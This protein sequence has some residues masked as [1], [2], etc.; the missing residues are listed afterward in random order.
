M[1]AHT[2]GQSAAAPARSLG[3]QPHSFCHPI[4]DPSRWRC[5][6]A[7]RPQF[8]RK[9]FYLPHHDDLTT[10]RRQIF[11]RG[12]TRPIDKDAQRGEIPQNFFGKPAVRD[13]P[14][15]LEPVTICHRGPANSPANGP[16][17]DVLDRVGGRLSNPIRTIA[18]GRKINTGKRKAN[19][20]SAWFP[21]NKNV[22]GSR[23]IN[24]CPAFSF[25]HDRAGLGCG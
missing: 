12:A 4:F 18:G 13:R 10:A 6:S 21:R 2:A 15:S 16:S 25:C 20:R 24:A 22:T 1:A 9:S 7:W 17:T 19:A 14:S 5:P 23:A 11:R 8:S 3:K